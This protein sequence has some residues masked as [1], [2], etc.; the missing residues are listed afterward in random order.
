MAYFHSI[1]MPKLQTFVFPSKCYEM[2]LR[3]TSPFAE[4]FTP[5][6]G[7]SNSNESY[8][9]NQKS[10]VFFRVICFYA[11]PEIMKPLAAFCCQK[12]LWVPIKTNIA[13][14]S[15]SLPATETLMNFIN[16]LHSAHF[17]YIKYTYILYTQLERATSVNNMK[18]G[19]P[20]FDSCMIILVS[21]SPKTASVINTKW[22]HR[23]YKHFCKELKNY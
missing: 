3:H 4:V 19:R 16:Y 22:Q 17:Q 11:L 13:L 23:K 14:K 21:T 15:S 6:A 9:S 10:R 12:N 8:I 18:D 20:D 5:A 2:N 1:W 7:V